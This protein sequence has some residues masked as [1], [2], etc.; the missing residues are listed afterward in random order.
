MLFV[1]ICI[2]TICD[3]SSM[4]QLFD[5][6]GVAQDSFP[7]GQLGDDTLREGLSLLKKLQEA[8]KENHVCTNLPS[9]MFHMV[10]DSYGCYY[11]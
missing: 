8:N 9:M 7:L 6:F 5:Q 3:Y 10:S 11:D 4:K 2:K 1:V